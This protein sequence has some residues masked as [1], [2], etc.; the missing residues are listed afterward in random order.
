[1]GQW[2][3]RDE[4]TCSAFQPHVFSQGSFRLGTAIHPL[5][6]TKGYDLDLGCSLESG[7]SP[8]SHTQADLKH[9]IGEELKA[10]RKAVGIEK[11][12]KAKHRCWCLEYQDKLNF[13]MDI[14]PCIPAGATAQ[15]RLS[16]SMMQA[17]IDEESSKDISDKSVYI[18]DDQSPT[19]RSLSND[20]PVSNP[21]GYADW[22]DSR[23]QGVM[24]HK[25]YAEIDRIPLNKRKTP[26]QRAIQLLKR[27]RDFM[28]KD[29]DDSKPISM[30]IT[31]LAAR[32]YGGEGDVHST[33]VGVLNKMGD[34][35]ADTSPRIPNPTNPGEDFADKW[36]MPGKEHLHLKENYF[37]WLAQARAFFHDLSFSTDM[38]H[39]AVQ[40]E[41]RL[42]VVLKSSDLR[43][44]LGLVQAAKL[45]A[46]V[47]TVQKPPQPWRD[48]KGGH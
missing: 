34:L 30:I 17:G 40:I 48:L 16:K 10:Y 29:H 37:E 12:V 3:G 28:F 7:I 20:W 15:H 33:L 45:A 9:L 24:I 36:D 44:E 43:N 27:H 22:F 5:D 2:F 21:I 32:A 23:M 4:S 26:L 47:A 31:T 38:D 25:A 14:V 19:F 8:E 35:V 41:R 42:S 39:S 6:A 1:V 13:H 11:A 18:T 46:P